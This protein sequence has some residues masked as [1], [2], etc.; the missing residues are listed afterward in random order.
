LKRVGSSCTSR[1]SISRAIHDVAATARPLAAKNGNRLEVRC[2]DDLGGA[3]TDLTRL[4]QVLLNLLSNACKFTENG[5]VVLEAARVA[6]DGEDWLTFT[7]RDT[8]IGMTPEQIDRVFEE[9]GQADSSTARKYG[10]TGLGLAI[11]RRLC[12]LMHGD[13]SVE[14]APGIGS[15]FTARLPG[16]AAVTAAPTR[17]TSDAL[18]AVS[19]GTPGR[20]Q[21]LVIDDEDTVRDLMRRF[22][23]REGFDVVTARDGEEGLAL[24]R[25]LRPSLITLDVMMPRRDGWSVLQEL[26]SDP[27]LSA[28]PILMLTILD[29]KKKGYALGAAEYMTKPIDRGRLRTLL[30]KYRARAPGQRILIV[31]D[32]TDIRQWLHRTLRGDDWQVSEAE[33]GRVALQ[34]VAEC[35]PDLILLDLIMP[36]MDGFEFLAELRKDHGSHDIPVI[37]VTAADLSESDHGRLNGGVERV[38]QKAALGR[39]QLLDELRELVTKYVGFEGRR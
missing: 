6:D 5:E 17:D 26:K 15:S 28:I 14:S 32:D 23:V 39:D 2:A 21:V 38:L 1:R 22:L 27:E 30:E 13:I 31:E 24:A 20:N 25:Q 16:T 8:G 3:V 29:D 11:S 18:E 33:N 34:R 10:G 9:F 19:G 4:R 37:V 36:E 12:Q 35:R 7:V